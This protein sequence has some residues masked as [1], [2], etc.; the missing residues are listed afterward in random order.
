MSNSAIL[1]VFGFMRTTAS[2]ETISRT[3]KLVPSCLQIKQNGRSLMSAMG[4]RATM[5]FGRVFQSSMAAR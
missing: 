5:G 2:D 4:A 1:R 3:I